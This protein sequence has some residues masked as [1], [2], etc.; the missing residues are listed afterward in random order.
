MPGP[1]VAGGG[2][3]LSVFCCTGTTPGNIVCQCRASLRHLDKNHGPT[4]LNI[5]C[6]CDLIIMIRERQEVISGQQNTD[7]NLVVSGFVMV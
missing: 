4:N 5:F 6:V 3:T 7:N 1:V 2:S